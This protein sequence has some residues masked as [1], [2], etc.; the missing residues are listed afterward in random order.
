[1]I[2]LV[3]RILLSVFVVFLVF[4]GVGASVYHYMTEPYNPGFLEYPVVT[5]VHVILGGFY[6][7]FVP[8]QFVG[9]IRSRWLNYHRLAGRILVSIG[10]LVGVSAFTI[11]LVIPFSGWPE[12][13]INGIFAVL[14]TL[15][16]CRGFIF[17]RAGDMFSIANG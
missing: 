11:A 3:M 14:F 12:S 9:K 2:E 10:L 6:L 8:F 5:A 17:I 1:M 15:F 16:L 13:V 4:V 7:A